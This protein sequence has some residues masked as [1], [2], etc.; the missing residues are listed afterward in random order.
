LLNLLCLRVHDEFVLSFWPFHQGALRPNC[1]CAC[2]IVAPAAPASAPAAPYPSTTIGRARIHRVQGSSTHGGTHS[3]LEPPTPVHRMPQRPPPSPVPHM[4]PY[5]MALFRSQGSFYVSVN[6]ESVW[7][8]HSSFLSSL[9]ASNE[10]PHYTLGRQEPR[11]W[12]I[13]NKFTEETS[14]V[15]TSLGDALPTWFADLEPVHL[16]PHPRTQHSHQG[17]R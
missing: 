17:M 12:F 8:P 7:L 1:G 6:N 16:C 14:I 13:E 10:A 9:A 5:R 2:A 4:P 3:S 15:S 11:R